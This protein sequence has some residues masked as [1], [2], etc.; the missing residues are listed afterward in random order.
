MRFSMVLSLRCLLE[1]LAVG[2]A[3]EADRDHERSCL[4]T[5]EVVK[6]LREELSA[7][8]ACLGIESG[9]LGPRMEVTSSDTNVRARKADDVIQPCRIECIRDRQFAQLDEAS[10]L[11]ELLADGAKAATVTGEPA[12]PLRLAGEWHDCH[13]R[14]RSI[15]IG[16]GIEVHA[17]LAVRRPANISQSRRA[18]GN[19][20]A[21]RA[22]PHIAALPQVEESREREPVPEL[23]RRGVIHRV[24][25]VRICY[26]SI[27]WI[28]NRQSVSAE[29][30]CILLVSA[31][32][33]RA[34]CVDVLH[35]A[36]VVVQL[37][38]PSTANEVGATNHA[39]CV[40]DGCRS[41]RAGEASAQADELSAQQIVDIALVVGELSAQLE[42]DV[43]GLNRANV[44]GE[45]NTA[46]A[47]LRTILQLRAVA[48]RGRTRRYLDYHVRGLLVVRGNR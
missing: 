10:V 16:L 43:L 27:C 3:I 24:L 5:V 47:E 13:T 31:G 15:R 19:K 17:E 25:R 40:A 28:G 41:V 9:V 45:L 6:T 37:Q 32:S 1:F 29:E 33:R 39:R 36:S 22:I 34:K 8:E 4:G 11:H 46:V 42:R 18:L 12:I 20:N 38:T 23:E 2:L 7:A 21:L 48:R 30:E 44:E 14:S 26:H 35:A